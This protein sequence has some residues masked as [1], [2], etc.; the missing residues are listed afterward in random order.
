MWFAVRHLAS[1]VLAGWATCVS[2]GAAAD[3][4]DY[5]GL[6]IVDV[7]LDFG[8]AVPTPGSEELIVTSVGIPLS[9]TDVRESIWHLFSLGYYSDIRVDASLRDGGV[10]LLFGQRVILLA[11]VEPDFGIL[12]D[13]VLLFATLDDDVV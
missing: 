7:N 8:G 6:P 2:L 9:M 10:V 11:K 13:H 4:N 12:R 1:L 5:L 3:I